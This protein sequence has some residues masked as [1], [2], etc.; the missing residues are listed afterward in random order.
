MPIKAP[1]PVKYEPVPAGKL[2]IDMR[3]YSSL[4]LSLAYYSVITNDLKLAYE[5]QRIEDKLD[6]LWS[7]LVMQASLAVRS[8]ADAESMVSV[9]KLANSLDKLSDAAADI[10]ELVIRGIGF[11]EAVRAVILESESAIVARIKVRNKAYAGLSIERLYEGIAGFNVVALRRGDTWIINP[12]PEQVIREGDVL[13][14]RGTEEA[15]ETVAKLLGDELAFKPPS[16]NAREEDIAERIAELKDVSEVM[17]DLAF[18]AVVNGDKAAADEVLLLEEKADDLY[19]RLVIDI[20]SRI[21][22]DS[23]S[24]A[25]GLLKFVTSMENIADAAAEM[26]TSVASGLPVHPILEI[27]EE[28]GIERIAKLVIPENFPETSLGELGL[29]ELG[30]MVIALYRDGKIHPLPDPSTKIKPGDK[31]LVKIYSGAEE[32]LIDKIENLGLKIEGLELEEE[33][34]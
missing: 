16:V 26:V 32:S 1:R 15:L 7:Q 3:N 13:V 33:E 18:H 17:V 25:A 23:A 9:F 24:E 29:E 34:D 8:A 5:V 27:V 30:V 2:L 22:R 6:T 10:A 21:G 11:S 12:E 19:H 14:V 28:T 20:I 4:M 31:L